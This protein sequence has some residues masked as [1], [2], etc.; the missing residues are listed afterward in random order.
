MA[1][2]L[3]EYFEEPWHQYAASGEFFAG[4]CYSFVATSGALISGFF[5]E[6]PLQ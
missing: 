1:H 3:W 2:K 6:L 5:E 4:N